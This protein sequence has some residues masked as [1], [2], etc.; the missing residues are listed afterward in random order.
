MSPRA[1]T[2]YSR[3][4]FAQV[5]LE[6]LGPQQGTTPGGH[7]FAR[8]QSGHD[9]GLFVVLGSQ[10]HRADVEDFQ[11]ALLEE[12]LVADENHV[13]ASLPLHGRVGHDNRLTLFVQNHLSGAK[14][15]GPQ[16]TVAVFQAARALTVRVLGSAAVLIHVMRP[17]ACRPPSGQN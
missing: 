13:T 8:Q 1:F 12:V 4:A 17:P 10:A 5:V 7:D 11:G 15:V 9:F 14:D 2:S 6:Q 3:T 16:V